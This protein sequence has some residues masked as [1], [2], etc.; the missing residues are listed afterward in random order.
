MDPDFGVVEVKRVMFGQEYTLLAILSVE[1]TF[2]IVRQLAKGVFLSLVIILDYG[3]CENLL[4]IFS[5]AMLV[6]K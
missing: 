6:G 1:C 4:F 5:P 2:S 3:R